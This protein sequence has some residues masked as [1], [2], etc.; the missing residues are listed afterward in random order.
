MTTERSKQAN[1]GAGYRSHRHIC[2]S[3]LPE[4]HALTRKGSGSVQHEDTGYPEAIEPGDSEATSNTPTN[5]LLQTSTRAVHL[6]TYTGIEGFRPR[7]VRSD[8]GNQFCQIKLTSHYLAL[9]PALA[10]VRKFR[11]GLA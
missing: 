7:M 1:D 8:S 6:V 10:V 5:I 11:R 4:R 9:N 3:N 2:G